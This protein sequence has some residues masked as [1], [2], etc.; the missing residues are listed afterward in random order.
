MNVI[1][2]NCQVEPF[3]QDIMDYLKQYETRNRNTLGRF[4]GERILIAETGHGSPLV[5]CIATIDEIISLT[6][7]EDWDEY[8]E[9]TYVPVGSKYDWQQDTKKKWLYHLTDIRPVKPFRLPKDCPRHG[10]VSA[11]YNGSIPC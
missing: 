9:V 7:K 11:E 5:K 6:T 10:R 3:V 1:F 2:I 8:L 4:L